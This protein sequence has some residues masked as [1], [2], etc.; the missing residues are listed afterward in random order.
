VLEQRAK[1]ADDLK[2]ALDAKVATLAASEDQLLRERTDRQGLRGG[3]S[4]SKPPSLT[5][6]RR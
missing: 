4:R 5:P 2:A 6:G 3:S 1:E